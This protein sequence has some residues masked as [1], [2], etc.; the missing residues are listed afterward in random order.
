MPLN[1]Q[2]QFNFIAMALAPSFTIVQNNG[3]ATATATNTTVYG[4][5]EEDRNEAAEY[6]LWSKTDKNGNRDF[7][8]PDQGDVLTKLAYTV[9]TPVSGLYEL[10][11]L[12]I[13]PY[14]NAT[15]YVEQQESGGVITQY[16][17]VVYYNGSVY[18]CIAPTT[19]NLPTD[20]TYWEVVP[21]ASLQDLLGNSNIEEY[22]KNWDGIY[23]INKCITSRLAEAGCDCGVQDREYNQELFSLYLAAKS[24]FEIGNI[25]EFEEII[26]ELNTKC[27]QC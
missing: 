1:F 26:E 27:V 24:N 12:R 18:K 4:S 11:W 25:Y 5:P 21:L 13:Q 23:Q 3:G 10:I 16:P 8:N 2:G 15:A 20:V 9:D 17:S 7:T 6:V 19:G 14:D 22:I